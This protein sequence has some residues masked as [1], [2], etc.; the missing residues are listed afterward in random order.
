[1]TVFLLFHLAFPKCFPSS[2]DPAFQLH[3]IYV[4]QNTLITM[5]SNSEG[6]RLRILFFGKSFLQYPHPHPPLLPPWS[7]ATIWTALPSSSWFSVLTALPVCGDLPTFPPADGKPLSFPGFPHSTWGSRPREYSSMKWIISTPLSHLVGKLRRQE[8]KGYCPSLH[9]EFELGSEFHLL[10]LMVSPPLFHGRF[11][12]LFSIFHKVKK[13]RFRG[14]QEFL[15]LEKSL[16]L[17][18][19]ISTFSVL[20]II[21]INK[22][23]EG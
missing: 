8:L 22:T 20:I 11:P 2:M 9:S 14:Q 21:I 16:D 7:D 13:R 12:S 18:F 5:E 3:R 10:T 15:M 1:M 4:L 17:S 19:I 23:F 6:L